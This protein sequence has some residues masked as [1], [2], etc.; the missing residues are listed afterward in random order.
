MTLY[1]LRMR[2]MKPPRATTENLRGHCCKN[3]V[4]RLPTCRANALLLCTMLRFC[5]DE[6]RSE[7]G[8]KLQV[9]HG[10]HTFPSI[11][12]HLRLSAS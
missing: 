1:A 6:A 3:R 10:L 4:D 8:R 9:I 2:E 12:N 7:G 5:T 11:S